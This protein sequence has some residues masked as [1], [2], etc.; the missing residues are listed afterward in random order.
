MAFEFVDPPRGLS[1]GAPLV[2]FGLFGNL[3]NAYRQGQSQALTIQDQQR[4]QDVANAFKDGQLPLDPATGLPDYGKIMQ[5]LASKGGIDAI[6]KLAPSA[7]DQALLGQARQMSPLLSPGGAA[8]APSGPTSAPP[9]AP[10]APQSFP[11]PPAASTAGYT[12]MSDQPG[13]VVDIVTSRLP[14]NSAATGAVIANIAKAAG[15]DP[16][17]ALTAEQS[18]RVTRLVDGYVARTAP[19]PASAPAPAPLVG[20]AAG[21]AAEAVASRFPVDMAPAIPRSAVA[22]GAAPAPAPSVVSPSAAAAPVPAAV[23]PAGPPA[24]AGGGPLVPQVPLPPGYTDPQK[25]ILAL[26]NEA[27]RLSVNPYSAGPAKALNDWATRIET[28]IAPIKM[29]QAETIV[30]PRTGHVLAQGPLAKAL[31]SGGTL[32]GQA[33][34]G[35]AERYFQTGQFPSGMTRDTPTNRADRLAIQERA[36][37]LAEQEGLSPGDLPTHWQQFA[38]RAAGLRTFEQRAA[39]LTLAENEAKTL[40]PRVREISHKIS[41]TDY[42]TLNSLILAAQ[43]GTGGQDVIR[44][45]IAVGSLIPVYARVLKPVGQVTEGDTHRAQ[46]ILDKAWSEGQIDAALDQMGIELNSAKDAL[47][48]AREDFG[49]SRRPTG[50]GGTQAAPA[51]PS[52]ADGAAA[53]G[54]VVRWE[55]GPDG[56][57][58]PAQ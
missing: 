40:I 43:K 45:G 25:A 13:S 12:P 28:S 39:G 49:G 51:A 41:R 3:P 2:N 16:N 55:R 32:S 58:R 4:Q 57:L 23:P 37:A 14:Q 52:T 1:Y 53:G 36:Y 7:A 30:D 34:E 42:P 48:N 38:T 19:R 8:A 33:L 21:S 29:G 47:K 22:S 20:P 50:G 56:K 5:V 54:S 15:V 44:L 31:T 9:A 26:R 27:A 6:T 18:A 10:Q 17:G 46:E 11:A 24:D 35:A